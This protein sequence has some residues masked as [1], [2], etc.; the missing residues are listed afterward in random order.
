MLQFLSVKKL[1]LVL[2][3]IVFSCGLGRK[4]TLAAGEVESPSLSNF[5]RTDRPAT[6]QSPVN[7][8]NT[9][10]AMRI[11]VLERQVNNL[12]LQLGKNLNVTT[13]AREAKELAS[14][15]WTLAVEARAIA[16]QAEQKAEK[17]LSK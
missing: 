13:T 1:C 7:S 2:I 4:E 3:L 8:S 11:E 15:A 6:R 12:S 9:D 16:V 14:D 10:M 5:S 17:A